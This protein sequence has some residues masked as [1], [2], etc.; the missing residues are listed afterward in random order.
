MEVSVDAIKELLTSFIYLS[1]GGSW[2]VKHGKS[3]F[4]SELYE[5]RRSLQDVAELEVLHSTLDFESP[6]LLFFLYSNMYMT[7]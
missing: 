1:S 3:R 6:F 2:L 4:S 7:T 5:L